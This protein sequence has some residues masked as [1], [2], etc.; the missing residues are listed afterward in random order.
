MVRT[1]IRFVLRFQFRFSL[2]NSKFWF[3]NNCQ[4]SLDMHRLASRKPGRGR[5]RSL[6]NSR[7]SRSGSTTSS[8]ARMRRRPRARP[9]GITGVS[10][11]RLSSGRFKKLWCQLCVIFW[12]WIHTLPMSVVYKCRQGHEENQDCRSHTRTGSHAG[13]TNNRDRSSC[14][15]NR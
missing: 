4:L 1:L 8:R 14:G 11:S 2:L 5:R 6:P 15:L 13:R 9:R 10:D 12:H 7:C 3:F